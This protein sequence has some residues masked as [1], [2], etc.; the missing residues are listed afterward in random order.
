MGTTTESGVEPNVQQPLDGGDDPNGSGTPGPRDPG[1]GG[2]AG[3]GQSEG[4][5]PNGSGTPGPRTPPAAVPA[6]GH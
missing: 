6:E 2:S 1:T 5:S 3:S 4:V